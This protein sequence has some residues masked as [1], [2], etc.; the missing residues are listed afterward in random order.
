[1]LDYCCYL[2]HYFYHALFYT[3]LPGF[4]TSCLQYM[5][6]PYIVFNNHLRET[7]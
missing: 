7:Y 2:F 1:M 6:P 4:G 3:E 5:K